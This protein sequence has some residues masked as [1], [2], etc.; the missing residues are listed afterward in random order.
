MSES[1]TARRYVCSSCETV[2]RARWHGRGSFAV[3][4]DCTTVPVVPQMGQQETANTWHVE[5]PECCR[6]VEPKM[7]ETVYGGELGE[8]Y[9]CPECGSSYQW[10]GEMVTGPDKEVP[11]A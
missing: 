1:Q 8:D 2:V 5:R 6:G 11:K 3:G 7:M 10:D 9:R 4:C